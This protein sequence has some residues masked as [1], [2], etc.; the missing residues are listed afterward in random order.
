MEGELEVESAC[1]GVFG[2]VSGR[3]DGRWA[4]QGD[5]ND[6]LFVVGY[7]VEIRGLQ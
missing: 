1:C 6:G 7:G 5:R 2:P 4:V 3:Y